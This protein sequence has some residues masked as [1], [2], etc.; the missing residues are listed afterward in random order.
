MSIRSQIASILGIEDNKSWQIVDTKTESHLYLIHY[1]TDASMVDYGNLRGIV[2]DIKNKTVVARSY[3]FTPYV[4]AESIRIADY[5]KKIHLTDEI[6]PDV[7]YEIDPVTTQFTPGFDGV[8]IRVFLHDGIVYHSSHKRID[9]AETSWG[10]S[11]TYLEMYEELDGPREDELFD[12]TKKYSPYVYV[13]LLAHPELQMVSKSPIG[14]GYLVYLGV[15]EMW[16]PNQAPYPSD[17]VE[18]KPKGIAASNGFIANPESPLLY[19][20]P[21]LG[22]TGVN[23]FLR[24]GFHSDLD[25]TGLDQRLYPGEFVIA[26]LYSNGVMTGAIRIESPG[27]QWRKNMRDNNPDLYRQFFLLSNG[28]F[29]RGD[30]E[31]EKNAYIRRFPILSPSGLDQPLPIIVWPQNGLTQ[32]EIDRILADPDH[33]LYNIYLCLIYS[34]PLHLQQD[35]IGFYTSYFEDRQAVTD[36]IISIDRRGDLVGDIPSRVKQIIQLARYAARQKLDQGNV[37]DLDLLTQEEIIKL[38]KLEEGG[39]LYKLI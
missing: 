39:S 3:G 13:F 10:F 20:P 27:Y 24:T 19:S 30:F 2:V 36:D 12:L 31:D 9:V 18:I 38:V 5:D 7:S 29:L 14:A 35:A 21:F 22:V 23:D 37:T 16:N 32:E 4:R 25:V 17:Q 8:V 11:K 15:R 26:F 28:R 34:L 33:R 6:N 1:T